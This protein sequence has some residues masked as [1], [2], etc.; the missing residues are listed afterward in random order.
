M[1]STFIIPTLLNQ[2]PFIPL[3]QSNIKVI[4]MTFFK[5]TIDMSHY[6][7]LLWDKDLAK[8]KGTKAFI[9]Y[10][11][12]IDY[13]KEVNKGVDNTSKKKTLQ[14]HINAVKKYRA[15]DY[16]ERMLKGDKFPMIFLLYQDN[17]VYQQEGNRR[18][19]AV[20]LLIN[21]GILP[22]DYK[23]PVAIFQRK[24]KGDSWRGFF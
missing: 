4:K 22:F 8:S 13:L 17:Q 9:K 11:H 19:M 21:S 24:G 15:K 1:P 2:N 23:I 5:K 12:P 16:S 10:M 20:Q 14:Q 18:A 6:D 7:N 3:N